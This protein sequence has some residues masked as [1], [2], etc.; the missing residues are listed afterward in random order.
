MAFLWALGFFAYRFYM[1][2]QLTISTLSE[3][4][5]ALLLGSLGMLGLLIAG[6]PKMFVTPRG[7]LAWVVLLGALAVRDRPGLDRRDSY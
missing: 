1:E 6:S 2:N 4:R 5:R 3:G 7:T